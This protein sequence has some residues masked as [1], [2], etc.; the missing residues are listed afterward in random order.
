MAHKNDTK[1]PLD[2]CFYDLQGS[3]LAFFQEQTG[4]KDEEELKK[5][6]ISVQEKAYEVGNLN[7]LAHKLQSQSI[8]VQIF[9]YRCIRR[10]DFTQYARLN[11]HR[12]A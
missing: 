1:I 9:G 8:H 3:D 10:F 2:D 4:I 5:H 12:G 11:S 7:H 6:I